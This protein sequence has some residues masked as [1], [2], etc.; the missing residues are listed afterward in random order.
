MISISKVPQF[1]SEEIHEIPA[2]IGRVDFEF[3]KD[4]IGACSLL[5]HHN[6]HQVLAKDLIVAGVILKEDQNLSTATALI[7]RFKSRK[8]SLNFII[9][10]NRYLRKCDRKWRGLMR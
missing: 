1:S 7:V 5:L 2:G 4:L 6:S 9:R 10:L 3:D 8:A